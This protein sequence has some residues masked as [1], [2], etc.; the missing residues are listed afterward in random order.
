MKDINIGTIVGFII[1]GLMILGEIGGIYHT[2]KKHGTADVF[3]SVV[4]P[5]W[6]WYRSVE[7]FWHDDFSDVDWD[8]R[9]ENDMKAC[10][11]FFN[12]VSQ[13]EANVYKINQD[14]EEYSRQILN[15]PA[16][17]KL[18]LKQGA[19]LYILRETA[20]YEDMVRTLDRYFNTGDFKFEFGQHTMRLEER[21]MQYKLQE[22]IQFQR[23]AIE[24]LMKQF[25][26]K[27]KLNNTETSNEQ[28]L[29]LTDAIELTN[30]KQ[31]TA[32][33]QVFRNIFN[34]EYRVIN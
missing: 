29:K 28:R 23:M 15:Y 11:Y 26:E 32:L 6:A 17:K 19:S 14:I 27:L 30:R 31:Q 24:E 5:P 20:L 25:E 12:M 8:K 33:R 16:E 21:L 13:K 7:L 34:E 18:F 9:L 2:A 10:V 22:D 1:Y 4:L 3:T